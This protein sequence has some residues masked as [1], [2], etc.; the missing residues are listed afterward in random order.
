M[1]KLFLAVIVPVF[2]AGC[3]QQHRLVEGTSVQ[4]GAYVPWESQLWGLELVS[5]VSGLSV[6]APTNVCLEVRRSCCSTNEF[7]WGMVK[8]VEA[9]DSKIATKR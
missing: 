6:K 7:L 4:L 5:Y 1:K 9:S 8:T 3:L 2:A